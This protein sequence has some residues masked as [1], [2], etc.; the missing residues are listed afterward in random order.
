[1]RVS[2]KVEV[3]NECGPQAMDQG[4]SMQVWTVEGQGISKANQCGR[5][6][7]YTIAIAAT[8]FRFYL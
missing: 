1:M 6:Q 3:L 7:L 2:Q 5:Q 4:E 8:L